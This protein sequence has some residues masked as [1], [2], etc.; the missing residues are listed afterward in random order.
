[1]KEITVGDRVALVDDCD[2]ELVSSY[3]WRLSSGAC[4]STRYARAWAHGGQRQEIRMHRLI[5]GLTGSF[6]HVDH[7]NGDGLDNRREN[8]RAATHRQNG[9]NAKKPRN[10]TSGYKG[11][12]L[13]KADGTYSAAIAGRYIGRYSTAEEAARAY[14]IEAVQVYGEYARLNIP[15]STLVPMKR[16]LGGDKR[17]VLYRGNQQLSRR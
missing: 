7:K 15:D 2:Y 14:D 16:P 5:L 10:N 4:Q 17:S 8:L 13:S 6:P 12:S 1:M 9:A 3:H 11:V